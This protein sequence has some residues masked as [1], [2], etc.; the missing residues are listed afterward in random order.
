[1]NEVNSIPH[2]SRGPQSRAHGLARAPTISPPRSLRP[3]RISRSALPQQLVNLATSL[4]AARRAVL[5][6]H[7]FDF[8]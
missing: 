8:T 6:S 5:L 7:C 2:S 1:M 3:T 4:A